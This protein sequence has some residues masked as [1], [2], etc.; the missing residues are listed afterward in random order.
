MPNYTAFLT[1][2]H[3]PCI[4]LY[5]VYNLTSIQKELNLY[6]HMKE[7]LVRNKNTRIHEYKSG[8]FD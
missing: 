5:C 4:Q 3:A 6:M 1:Y 8:L 7:L 2:K